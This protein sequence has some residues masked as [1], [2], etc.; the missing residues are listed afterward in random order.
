MAVTPSTMIPLG[1]SCPSFGLIDTITGKTFRNTDFT[2]KPLLVM[3]I[4]NH[5]PYV[6]HM[7][8]E[9]AKLGCEYLSRGI[10]VVGICSNDAETYPSDS[11]SN[12]IEMAKKQGWTFP[13]LHDAT[14]EVARAFDAA[15]TPDFFLFDAGHQLV[16]RGQ[17]DYSRPKTETPVNGADL[18]A[19]LDA[20]L[21]G[22]VPAAFQRPSIGCNIKWRPQSHSES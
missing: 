17:L 19:A 7:Q 1:T 22:R 12:M 15:C 4:C 9:L 20:I 3:F 16:Y 14:Q 5:C 11:P 21:D 18:R 13:Y 8:N 6:V 2:G 10:A